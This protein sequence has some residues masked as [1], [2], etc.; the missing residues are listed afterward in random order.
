MGTSNFDD[1]ILEDLDSAN[2]LATILS[3][4]SAAEIQFIDGAVAGTPA[5]NKALILDAGQVTAV[6]FIDGAVAGTPAVNK[7]LV[8]DAGQVTVINNLENADKLQKTVKVALV[9]SDAAAGVFSWRNTEESADIIVTGVV[10][11]VTTASSG[12]CTLDIG[13]AATSILADNLIDGLDVNAAVGVFD[14]TIE[15]GTNGAGAVLVADDEYVTGSMA[16]GAAAGL[17]GFAYIT[18]M[19]V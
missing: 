12:A 8:L 17:A 18:Y 6:G 15:K 10:L 1:I 5:A 3:G 9:A 11:N 4:M 2:S 14:S 19:V 16:S 7:A 13:F